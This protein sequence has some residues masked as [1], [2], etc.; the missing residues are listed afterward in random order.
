M[1][2]QE[3]EPLRKRISELES[4]LAAAVA[5]P[6]AIDTLTVFEVADDSALRAQLAEAEARA[7]AAERR[8]ADAATI[9]QRIS[10]LELQ[11]PAENDDAQRFAARIAELEQ[12]LDT[13][14][15][16]AGEAQSLRAQILSL[17][18]RLAEALAV[19]ERSGEGEDVGLLKARLAD[20]EARLMRSS[21]SSM[22]FE[23]L[24]SR[25]V[26]LEGLLHEAAKSRDEAAVLR[27][28]VA[29]LD[30]RLGQAMKA[31][32]ETRPRKPESEVV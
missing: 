27:S 10:E 25:V 3:T 16:Q 1:T 9:Q 5:A 14:R 28:K 2:R 24:R 17:E 20:V 7:E 30:G 29:E 15:R 12:S 32:A 19:A 4:R 21:Q 8:A 26:T 31:M 11:R 23:S 22:E 6:A 18:T 13:A